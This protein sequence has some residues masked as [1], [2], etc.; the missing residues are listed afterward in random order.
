MRTI[1][2]LTGMAAILFLLP[3][4]ARA[5]ETCFLRK[6]KTVEASIM[7]DLP[8]GDGAVTGTE[9]GTVQ[10]DE[11]GYYTSWQST[12]AG[13]RNGNALKVSVETKI[14]DDLQKDEKTYEIAEDGGLVVDGE[15]YEPADCK[16]LQQPE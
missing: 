3:A 2:T 9:T 12:I 4:G 10:D 16:D 5:D 14:E 8:A 6:T 7:L 1:A 13:T 15:R 11:Q